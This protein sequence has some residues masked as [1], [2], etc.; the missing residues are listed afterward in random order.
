MWKT[1]LSKITTKGNTVNFV[2]TGR[3]N[4]LDWQTLIYT[5]PIVPQHIWKN[6]SATEITTGNTDDTSKMVGTGPFVY[7]AGKGTSGTLQWNR[8]DGWW[9]TKAFGM[10]MPMQ[11]LVDI[12]NSSNSASLPSFLAGQ[13]RPQQQLLP[14]GRQ[15]PRQ[16]RHR[17]VLPGCAVHAVG[18]HGV[19]RAEH[20]AQAAERRELP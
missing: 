15:V 1:G 16:G 8:R 19:A 12:H 9:A 5:L 13:H 6:Y 7:G 10:K 11:Y 2:F 14:R 20:D 3:P 17:V 18:E 4:Y